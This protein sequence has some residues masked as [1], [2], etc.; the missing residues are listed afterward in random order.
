MT[1][2]TIKE[3]RGELQ[4]AFDLVFNTILKNSPETY[5]LLLANLTNVA[6]DKTIPATYVI[7]DTRDSNMDWTR[8]N[9]CMNHMELLYK[10]DGYDYHDTSAFFNLNTELLIYFQAWESRYLLKYLAAIAY[11][12]KTSK[13]DYE[14]EINASGKSNFINNKII[15]IFRESNCNLGEIIEKI[16][17][18][19][20]R[21]AIAHSEYE[22]DVFNREIRYRERMNKDNHRPISFESFDSFQTKFLF[23]ANLSYVL[24]NKIE[25]LRTEYANDNNGVP[26]KIVFPDNREYA[27]MAKTSTSRPYCFVQIDN[28]YGNC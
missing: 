5:F 25:A 17:S 8:I 9:F 18:A 2:K 14:L 19:D 13:F 26:V 27:F 22:I 7:E 6:K 23:T 20:L 21:N 24:H 11:A 1:E 10:K 4:S 16:Y 12:Y 3:I 28:T 15:G